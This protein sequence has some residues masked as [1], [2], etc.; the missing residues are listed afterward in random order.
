MENKSNIIVGLDIGTTKI[1][2]IVGRKN[3]Q[4]KIEIM[5]VGK[6]ESLGIARGMV[7]N[8]DQTVSS[9]EKAVKEASDKSGVKIEYVNVGIAGQHIK[10][11]QHRGVYTRLDAS[12]E[13]TQDDVDKL[14]D[15]MERLAMPP[16]EE[17]IEVLPQEY[18]NQIGASHE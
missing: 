3:E 18:I 13:I 2:A 8:I 4:N 12:K 10:S 17:I 1:V 15:S 6:A 7:R 9:I 5:G 14:I 11:L 16:G